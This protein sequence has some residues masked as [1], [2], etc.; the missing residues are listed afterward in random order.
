[1]MGPI[2]VDRVRQPGDPKIY[3]LIVWWQAARERRQWSPE[4]CC[5]MQFL[6]ATTR[7]KLGVAATGELRANGRAQPLHPF[8]GQER[9]TRSSRQDKVQYLDDISS[10][11]PPLP[12]GPQA[13][14]ASCWLRAGSIYRAGP[15]HLA[16]MWF[17][18]NGM[19][20]PA[21]ERLDESDTQP[22]H[23]MHE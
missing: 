17:C 1:M 16:C 5:L 22:R 4:I 7:L 8:V 14:N 20:K 9:A 3:R 10:K 13:S 2:Q 15:R 19:G 6:I 23:L 11:L 18:V 12:D 21:L